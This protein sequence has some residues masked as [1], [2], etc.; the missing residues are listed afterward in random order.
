M[1]EEKIVMRDHEI[2]DEFRWEEFMKKQDRRLDRYMELF[3]RFRDNPNRDDIIFRE[4]GWKWMLDDGQAGEHD[5]DSDE[6]QEGEEWKAA[7][8]VENDES[9]ELHYYKH[10]PV[11]RRSHE[12]AIKA[13]HI[14]EQLPD[15]VGKDSSVVDF[16]SGAMIASAKI[17]GGTGIGQDIEELGGNI[18]FCKRGLVSANLA[19]AALREIS[20]KNIIGSS[21]YRELLDEATEVRNAIAVHI[22]ELRE[23]FRR[24]V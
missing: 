24:G 9:L 13:F 23:K 21:L 22:I 5:P 3:Y 14:A 4:M 8:G 11:Y 19:I 1:I 16:V 18:A 12:F 17:A 6:V 7:A 15:E 2:W 10:L 20:E